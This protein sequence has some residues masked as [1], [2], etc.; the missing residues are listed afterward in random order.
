MTYKYGTVS[1]NVKVLK[2]E[3]V[4]VGAN[5]KEFK[6]IREL[7]AEENDTLKSTLK[8]I[9]TSK[10][11]LFN[12]VEKFDKL[13]QDLAQTDTSQSNLH[14]EVDDMVDNL[15]AEYEYIKLQNEKADLL[16]LFY[17]KQCADD[18]EPGLSRTE[19]EYL[20][21]DLDDEIRD[22]FPS[23]DDMDKN[24]DGVID[25]FEFDEWLDDIYSQIFVDTKNKVERNIGDHYK[26]KYSSQQDSQEIREER[27]HKLEREKQRKPPLSMWKLQFR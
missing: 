20:L 11:A 26:N 14:R 24:N 9:H 22:R 8:G 21:L 13:S 3:A 12:C 2:R 18:D 7:L 17:G 15:F 19:Y 16:K 23:F 5:V 27:R 4:K 6:E 1:S 10:N 25:I